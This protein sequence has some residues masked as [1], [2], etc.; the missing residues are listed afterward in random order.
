[1]ASKLLLIALLAVS[2]TAIKAADIK[3]ESI[4]YKGNLTLQC[5]GIS[6]PEFFLLP[7]VEDVVVS[8]RQVAAAEEPANTEAA[9]EVVPKEK[10]IEALEGK[11]IVEGDT[12]IINEVKGDEIKGTLSCQ[13]KSDPT[14]TNTFVFS[15][16]RPFLYKPDKLSLTETEGDNAKISCR[17]LYGS[18]DLT[19]SWL[20]DGVAVPTESQDNRFK[21][22]SEDKTATLTIAKVTETDKGIYE[23]VL[24]NKHGEHSEKINLR[25]KSALAALWPFLGIVAEVFILCVI[26]LSYETRCGKKKKSDDDEGE[27]AQNLMG[28]DGAQTSDVKKRTAKA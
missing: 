14:Q 27:Q 18:D 26:I 5:I 24:K 17:V 13:S 3:I 4:G 20:K 23:C 10:K 28:R 8:K 11:Y 22:T 6:D 25:V 16:V 2:L 12:L 19:W 21:A 9:K 15:G 1:M 7:K